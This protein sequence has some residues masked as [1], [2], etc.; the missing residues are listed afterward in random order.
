[1]LTLGI[2][3]AFHEP[4]AAL[5]Q[6]RHIVAA[7]EEAS[8]SRGGRGDAILREPGPPWPAASVSWCL[9]YHGIS[10]S[11]V[12]HTAYPWDP[13]L[14]ETS[15]ILSA[16][17]RA[18][19]PDKAAWW[20][21][22][23][24]GAIAWVP[25]LVGTQTAAV[26]LC[27]DT[28][29]RSA[30]HAVGHQEAHAA[31]AFLTSPFD[32]AAI[33]CVNARGER[34]STTYGVGRGFPIETLRPIDAGHSLGLLYEPVTR[35]LGFGPGL[36]EDKVSA[37]AA[38]GRPRF[39]EAFREIVMRAPTG[40]QY[41]VLADDLSLHL[42]PSRAPATP[43]EA[44]HDDIASSL[45]E[46]LNETVVGLATWLKKATGAQ[47]VT[48]GGG[49]FPN[50]LLNSALQH[51]GLFEGLWISPPAGACCTAVGGALPV[52]HRQ[53]GPSARVTLQHT[54][55][56]P[57]FTAETIEALL[58]RARPAYRRPPAIAVAVAAR[59]ASGKTVGWFQGAMEFP[60]EALGS[61]V[62]LAAATILSMAEGLNDLTA[63]EAFEQVACAVVATAVGDWFEDARA[64][65]F[66]SFV[67]RVHSDKRP[68]IPAATHVDGTARV[69]TVERRIQ[70]LFY[71]LIEAFGAL[72][73]VPIPLSA[74]FPTRGRPRGC[75]PQDP[76]EAYA[77]SPLDALAL[78]AFLL[79]KNRSRGK[80]GQFAEID[81]LPG[82]K[83][84]DSYR[85]QGWHGAAPEPLRWVP[86]PSA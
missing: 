32:N 59:L 24:L 14:M 34:A 8:A 83:A 23:P 78:G 6:D 43:L 2:T 56:G 35:H 69:Q 13:A 85:A 1:M 16:Q 82:L 15:T 7:L 48:A 62:V 54:W 27:A 36:G 65:A 77:R 26:R 5:V 28:R 60:R 39:R 70:P 20:G 76:I 41:T 52:Y 67:A 44:P 47:Y 51:A 18:H 21:A 64:A 46:C 37:L 33:L 30:W 45:Q 49:V 58:V 68:R 55:W 12:D 73:G 3:G 19:L 9:A 4:A 79:E 17:A 50:T 72:T 40:G 75:W 31:A 10:L 38:S 84:G 29:P 63:H 61:R 80:T 66:R 57:G 22:L 42:G 74:D 25:R 86:G 81:I 11:D 71:D 53:R